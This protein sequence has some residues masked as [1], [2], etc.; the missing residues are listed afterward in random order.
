MG[1]HNLPRQGPGL[2]WHGQTTHHTPPDNAVELLYLVV[3]LEGENR[4][5]VCL[6]RVLQRPVLRPDARHP[7]VGP[8]LQHNT[9]HAK[10][11]ILG[12]TQETKSDERVT[13]HAR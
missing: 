7:I 2:N 9:I 6:E 10:D 4:A 8:W 12:I 13:E 1:E 3:P 5:L 11:E